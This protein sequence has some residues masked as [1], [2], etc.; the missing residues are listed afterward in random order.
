MATGPKLS[1]VRPARKQEDAPIQLGV[2]LEPGEEG[3]FFASCPE[4]PGCFSYGDTEEE[5]LANMRDAIRTHL[6]P[7][8]S[9]PVPA[10][11]KVR[12]LTL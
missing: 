10:N 9:Q 1:Q 11:A 5:A 6:S 8:D 4:I 7:D 12:L 2:I 3:G